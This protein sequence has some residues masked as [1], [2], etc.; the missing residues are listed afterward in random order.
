MN[1]QLNILKNFLNKIIMLLKKEY[2]ELEKIRDKIVDNN[3]K[4]QEILKF[5]D[6]LIKSGREVEINNY[7]ISSGFNDINSFKKSLK[8]DIISNNI[9]KGIAILGS[10]ILLNYILGKK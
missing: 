5:L 10:A 2:T 7:L 1:Y 3:F 4:P 6:L 8:K 9:I